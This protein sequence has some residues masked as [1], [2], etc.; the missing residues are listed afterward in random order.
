[1]RKLGM[2]LGQ[3]MKYASP[4]FPIF[5]THNSTSSGNIN[6]ARPSREDV[7]LTRSPQILRHLVLPELDPVLRDTSQCRLPFIQGARGG[8]KVARC[9][10]QVRILFIVESGVMY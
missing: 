7:R 6:S 8:H 3:S 4:S 9:G 1:M 5:L 10:V 2:V